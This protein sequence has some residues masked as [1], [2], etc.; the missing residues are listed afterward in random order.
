MPRIEPKS[1]DIKV[2][3]ILVTIIGN[4]PKTSLEGDHSEPKIKLKKPISWK[5]GILAYNTKNTIAKTA[6]IEN[7][8]RAINTALA[9][10]SFVKASAKFSFVKRGFLSEFFAFAIV[11]VISP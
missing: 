11:K 8:A 5:A 9:I 3:T 1:T 10:F 4:I 7:A 6:K 2:S